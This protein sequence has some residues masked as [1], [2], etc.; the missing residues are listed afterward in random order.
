[1]PLDTTFAPAQVD[2]AGGLDALQK[3]FQAAR[4]Q[5]AR[6]SAMKLMQ[7]GNFEGGVA[8][9]MG[10]GDVEGAKAMTGYWKAMHP[11]LNPYQA[12]EAEL[13]AER[14]SNERD[15]TKLTA[16]NQERQR[17]KDTI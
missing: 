4:I 11:Q 8:Q 9:L 13:A 6:S 7:G 5:Q 3:Q 2:V 14:L 1:M 12:L 15:R 17:A 10:A 16:E